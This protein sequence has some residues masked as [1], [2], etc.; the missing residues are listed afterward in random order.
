MARGRGPALL[1]TERQQIA[2]W[3]VAGMPL[4]EVL[5]LSGRGQASI[6][7]VWAACGGFASPARKPRPDALAFS[8]REEIS[9]GL[10][11]G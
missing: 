11:A 2:R 7:R 6:E 3:L 8:E 1:E 4:I 5:A 10:A 9:R